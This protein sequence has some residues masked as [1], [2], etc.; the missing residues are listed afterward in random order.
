MGRVLNGE[1]ENVL[2]MDGGDGCT[3]LIINVFN[4]RV[5]FKMVNFMLHTFYLNKNNTQDNCVK[6]LFISSPPSPHF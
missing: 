1:D 6:Y 5:H 3:M 4:A 2:K